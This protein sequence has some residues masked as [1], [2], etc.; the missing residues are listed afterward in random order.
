VVD[1]DVED[2]A[3]AGQDVEAGG[4]AAVFVAGDLAGVGAG[5]LGE[6]GLG[7]AAFG[8]QGLEAVAV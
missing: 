5:L 4:D 3:D 6:V 1:G 8:A 2:F 7:P